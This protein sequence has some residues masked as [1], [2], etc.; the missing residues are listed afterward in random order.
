MNDIYLSRSAIAGT[1]VFAARRFRP[2]EL[3]LS[4]AEGGPEVVPYRATVAS[5]VEGFYLQVGVD[6]YILPRPPSRYVNH[7]CDPNAGLRGL[8]RLVALAVIGAGEEITFD[9]STSMAEDGWEMDC[10]CGA[11]ACRGRVRDFRHLPAERQSFYVRR[12]LVGDFCVASVA[13]FTG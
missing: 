10:E 9:Y 6:K 5:I 1:G 8:T 3:V 7:G 4:F 12:G 13:T 2:G 11:A